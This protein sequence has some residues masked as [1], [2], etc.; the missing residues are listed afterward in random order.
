MAGY[1]GNDEA[2]N[3][4]PI[5]PFVPS[6]PPTMEEKQA[7]E[8]KNLIREAKEKLHYAIINQAPI[9]YA[10]ELRLDAEM[11]ERLQAGLVK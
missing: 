3:K 9:G 5:V 8:Y 4:E 11:Y 10:N 7:N 2:G 6:P 1:M